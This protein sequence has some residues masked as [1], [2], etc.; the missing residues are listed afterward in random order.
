MTLLVGAG[1][2]S[3]N[4]TEKMLPFPKPAKS[5]W[6][7]EP[8]ST[9]AIY[10]DMDCRAIAIDNGKDKILFVTF[11]LGGV[12]HIEDLK[13]LIADETGYPEDSIF[14]TATH[15][16]TGYHDHNNFKRYTE[17][18]EYFTWLAEVKRVEAQAALDAAKQ[19][20]SSMRPAKFGYGETQS[21][22]NTNR[23]LQTLGGYWV[24]ARNLGGYS[25]KTLAL[26]KFVDEEDHVIAVLMNYGCHATCCYLMKDFDGLMKSSGNFNGIASRFVEQHYGNGC[27]AMWTSGAAGN[28]NPLLS[29]GLQYEYPDGWTSAV[30]YPD[31]VGW[32]QMESM[33][34]TH[35]AD[36]VKGIDAI[37]RYSGRMPIRY[38]RKTAM[39]PGQKKVADD[40]N[41]SSGTAFRMGGR[42]IRN[43]D[44]V[45]YGEIPP[46]PAGHTMA[47]DP[48]NPC[49]LDMELI[50][51][52]DIAIVR[53]NAELYAEIGRDMK[54]ASPFKKTFVMTHTGIRGRAGYILDKTAAER[55]EKVFQAFGTT[56]PGACEEP[57]IQTETEMFEEIME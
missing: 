28:V 24:E 12:P 17:N 37:T 51:L 57:I 11:E 45:P 41:S 10:D 54:A 31:G 39:L 2:A 40:T 56:R 25:D 19:A 15:N 22:V 9:S 53:A 21:F 44:E 18:E 47:E 36:C 42:G 38:T 33:G 8:V 27:V 6:G 43:Y 48:E 3:L 46:V 1:K 14:L 32:M 4:P 7:M 20:V 29:H 50:L 26:I 5:D 55:N 35:G 34:R 13:T 16:H 52:G 49:P 30:D 23:D